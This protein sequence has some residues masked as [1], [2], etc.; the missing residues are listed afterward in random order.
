MKKTLFA[1]ILSL[2][3]CVVFAQNATPSVD[4]VSVKSDIIETDSVTLIKTQEVR[5]VSVTSSRISQEIERFKYEE[6]QLEE[7]LKNVRRQIKEFERLL[8]GV[9]VTEK[10]IEIKKK[11]KEDD[12]K[13]KAEKADKS[14]KPILP[15]QTTNQKK[16]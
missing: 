5:I 8:G 12:E 4:S 11:A 3:T 7:K 13:K 9:V 10:N 15:N 1:I 14:E 2:F 6:T 16:N